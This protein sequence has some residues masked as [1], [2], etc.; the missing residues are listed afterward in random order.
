MGVGSAVVA[1]GC[2]SGPVPGVEEVGD[3]KIE[4]GLGTADV[5]GGGNLVIVA[6]GV[7]WAVDM[8]GCL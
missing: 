2:C 8:R 7:S 4:D 6:S 3:M 1:V 5:W